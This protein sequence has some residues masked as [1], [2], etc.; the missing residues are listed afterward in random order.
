MIVFVDNFILS[1]R[2]IRIIVLSQRHDLTH[3]TR[4]HRRAL[5]QLSSAFG[6]VRKASKLARDVAYLH[7]LAAAA[8]L[9]VKEYQRLLEMFNKID[10]EKVG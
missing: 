9:T 5:E 10:I 7:S 8:G 2:F 4:T 3:Y 6:H 1:M